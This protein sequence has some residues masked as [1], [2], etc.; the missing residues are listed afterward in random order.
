MSLYNHVDNKDDIYD[1]MIDWVFA[2]IPLPDPGKPWQESLRGV[3]LAAL[4]RFSN[5]PWVVTLLM[6]RGNFGPASLLFM[7]RV[8]G[9][10]R[11][12]GFSDEDAH[13]AWQML[14]SHTMGYTFQAA[15]GTRVEFDDKQVLAN[16]T[17]LGDQCPHVVAMAPFLAHCEFGAEYAFGL[18]IIISGLEARLD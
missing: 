6:Q 4:D 9:V 7:D 15:S 8:L 14:A 17:D 18:E 3:G 12:A 2:G 16:L 13:H 5:H 11:D 10:L 1:G